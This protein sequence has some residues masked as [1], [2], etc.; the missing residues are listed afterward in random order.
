MFL[1]VL[2]MSY[3]FLIHFSYMSYTYLIHKYTYLI[4]F[5]YISY[6][7]LIRFFY[8]SHTCLI[9]TLYI[10]IHVL[11]ISLHVLYFSYVRFVPF[12][13][14][15]HYYSVFS[16]QLMKPRLYISSANTN[17]LLNERTHSCHRAGKNPCPCSTDLPS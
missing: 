2:D 17:V 3:T 7:F 12:L 16:Y 14:T 9:H 11:Y 1:H 6:T 4:H 13:H 10:S 15:P 8:I 5:L